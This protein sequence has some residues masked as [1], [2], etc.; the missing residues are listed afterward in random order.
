MTGSQSSSFCRVWFQDMNQDLCTPFYRRRIMQRASNRGEMVSIH[1][2][3]ETNDYRWTSSSIRSRL[4]FVWRNFIKLVRKNQ[5]LWAT[6]RHFENIIWQ[7]LRF[8]PP[9][10][11]PPRALF[12]LS[13]FLPFSFSLSKTLRRREE[14]F[15]NFQCFQLWKSG[16]FQRAAMILSRDGSLVWG[17]DQW[18][19]MFSLVTQ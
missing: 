5:S 17:K 7:R 18:Y 6:R 10:H 19:V 11:D 15:K 1:W 2:L 13:F 14:L 16:I 9:S 3:Y 8:I 4:I 12:S